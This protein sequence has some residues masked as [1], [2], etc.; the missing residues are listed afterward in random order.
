M[1]ILIEGEG[2]DINWVA[3]GVT[4]VVVI[5]LFVG[6]YLLF[7]KSPELIEVVAPQ[8]LEKVEEISRVEVSPESLL[9][10]SEFKELRR[11]GQEIQPPSPGRDN[12]FAPF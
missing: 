3:W 10:S 5:S 4:A 8:R 9:E 6:A 1:A 12:P 2:R 11:Y 7:F